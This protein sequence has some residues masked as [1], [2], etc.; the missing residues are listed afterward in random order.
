[1]IIMHIQLLFS[2]I[3]LGAAC[4]LPGI[5]L[6][7]RKTAMMSDAISHALLP[8][9]AIGFLYTHQVESPLLLIGA[10]I[11]SILTVL[12]TEA[13]I[14]SKKLNKDAA[15]GIIYP[16]FFSIGVIIINQA[17]R[18]IHLDTDIVLLG[19]LA[20]APL[21][22]LILYGVDIGPRVL[23]TSLALLICNSTILWLFYKEFIL[24]TIDQEAG[25]LLG[26]NPRIVH[27][28]VTIMT[29]ITA[30]IAFDSV[31][32]IMVIAL[33]ITPAATARLIATS[34]AMLIEKTILISSIVGFFGYL[35]ATILDVSIGGTIAVLHGIVFFITVPIYTLKQ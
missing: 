8:G 13:I 19:E 10:L 34:C 12:V 11:S 29:S 6:V 26:F 28:V 21:N 1:M 9:I 2:I 16:L 3:L 22:R 27:Y 4:A 7:L 32:S 17:A 23:Y 24:T 5:L 14:Q 33:M 25:R 20:L 35:S 31:G 30:I 18:N 15:I